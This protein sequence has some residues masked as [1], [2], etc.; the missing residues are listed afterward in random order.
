ML[1]E[2][3]VE[4]FLSIQ[5]EQVLSMVASNDKTF[6]DS[7]TNNDKKLTLLKSSV[8]YGANAS[9]KSNI[10]KALAIMRQ[11]VVLS[12]GWQRGRKLPV[13]PFLLGNEDNKPTK[14]EIIFIQNGIKYQYGFTLNTEKILEEWLFTFDENDTE[15]NWFERIYNKK[16]EKYNYS[17]G[18]RFLADEIYKNLWKDSTRDNALFLSV[19][20]QLNSEH[21][22]PVFDFFLNNL[23][24]TCGDI[25]GVME[26]E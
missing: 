12:A 19:A 25:N 8:I 2:F 17:F 5:D 24:V 23:R 7:H 1:V 4:N 26:K 21:L 11:I 18:E 6:L 22:K 16:E 14:F 15:Q 9:G 3:R 20:I 10:I 13:T